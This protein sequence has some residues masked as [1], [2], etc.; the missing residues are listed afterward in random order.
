V[1]PRAGPLE[2]VSLFALVVACGLLRGVFSKLMREGGPWWPYFVTGIFTV[3][4]WIWTA[5]RS[6]WP[7]L[8]STVG[9][10]MVYNLSWV[11]MTVLVLGKSVSTSQ[12]IGSIVVAIGLI[13][14]SV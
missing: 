14:M 6:P 7:L 8:P 3:S 12:A 11:G 10:Q 13:L 4:S 1:T 5:K 9:W 2:L